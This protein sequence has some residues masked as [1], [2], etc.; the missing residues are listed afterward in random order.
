VLKRMSLKSLLG[1]STFYQVLVPDLEIDL[2]RQIFV[3]L[4]SQVTQMCFSSDD[5]PGFVCIM[6]M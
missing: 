5:S 2:F 4:S 3:T 1:S 6:H